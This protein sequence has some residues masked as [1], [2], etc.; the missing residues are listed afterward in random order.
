MSLKGKYIV[1]VFLIVIVSRVNGQTCCSGGTPITGNL[2]IQGIEPKSWYFQLLY[3]YNIL[4]DLYS[5]SEKLNGNLSERLTQTVMLQTIYSFTEKF[6]VNGLYSYVDQK[7]SII[8]TTGDAHVTQA[9]GFG[10]IVLLAQYT[11]FLNLKRSLTIAIGPKLPVGKFDATD[12]E[13][14][15]VLSPDLQPGSGLLDG[16]IGVNFSEFHLFNVP[17]LTF[18]SSA[19]F[20]ITTPAKRFEGDFDYRFGNETVVAVGLQKSFLI[21]KIGFSP[22]LFFNFRNTLQDK[23]DDLQIPGTGGN[24]VNML[25]GLNIEPSNNWAINVSGELPVYRNL[26]GTQLTTTYRINIGVAIKIFN[27]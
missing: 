22:L 3:D 13:Y 18:N 14:G 20:R 25:L 11:P 15:L 27:N 1:F 12:P 26:T 4:D 7:R 21:N 8:G 24:W 16:I 17:G 19:G 5:G 6:S 9:N 10:D 23:I 2:G